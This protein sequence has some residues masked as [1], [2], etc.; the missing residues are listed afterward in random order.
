[1]DLVDHVATCSPCF[2]TYRRRRSVYRWRVRTIQ[3][4]A[5]LVGIVLLTVGSRGIPASSGLYSPIAETLARFRTP[6]KQMTSRVLDLR[7]QGATR[8]ASSGLADVNALKL[9]RVPLALTILLRIGSDKGKY[10]VVLTGPR[11][12]VAAAGN[13]R[14]QDFAQA[15]PVSIDLSGLQP[16]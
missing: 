4:I 16:G 9:P 7:M 1:G 13:A 15:L 14:M 11:D 2:Q 12:S 5:S 10:D 6:P 8:G 3:V